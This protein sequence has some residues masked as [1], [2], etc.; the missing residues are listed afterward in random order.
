M[1]LTIYKNIGAIVGADP[2]PLPVKAGK[3][4]A[5]EKKAA[6]PKKPVRRKAAQDK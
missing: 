4:K 6:G 2:N 3:E 1:G 5:E